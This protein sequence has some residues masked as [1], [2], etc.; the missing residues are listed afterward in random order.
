MLSAAVIH[1][2]SGGFSIFNDF[3]IDAAKGRILCRH[4]GSVKHSKKEHAACN[5]RHDSRTKV[6]LHLF[7][8]SP[9][10]KHT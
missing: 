4:Q 1:Q 2:Q 8:V 9:T 5:Y 7:A 3:L 10:F 6:E